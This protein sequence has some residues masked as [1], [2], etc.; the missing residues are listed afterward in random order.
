MRVVK[1]T[2]QS[3]FGLFWAYLI[4]SFYFVQVLLLFCHILPHEGYLRIGLQ[5][6]SSRSADRFRWS[7]NVSVYIYN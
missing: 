7:K 2:V 6:R 4:F 1:Y 3:N 5:C